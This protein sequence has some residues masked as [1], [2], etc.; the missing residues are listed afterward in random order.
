[1]VNHIAATLRHQMSIPLDSRNKVVIGTATLMVMA[2]AILGVVYL[3]ASG[4]GKREIRAQFAQAAGLAK[5]DS[6]SVAGVPVGSVTRTRLSGT[7]VTVD[8]KIDDNVALGRDTRASIKLTTLLGSRYVELQPAGSAGL[9]DETIALSH[10]TVPYDLQQVLGN[11]TTTF[12]QIDADQIGRSMTTLARQL[13]QTPALI[14]RVLDNVRVLSSVIADR[15]TQIGDLLRS[16]EQ[17]TTIVRGQQHNL[18]ELVTQGEQVLRAVL[19]RRV[20]ITRLLDATTDVAARLRTL[21][22]DDRSG[23]DRLITNLDGL[24]STLRRND[25]LLRNTLEILPVPIRNFANT[26]GTGNEVDFSDPAGPLVD[27]W[28]CAISKQ[29]DVVNLPPYFKDCR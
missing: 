5:G 10:T 28:M 14:P 4:I 9:R 29:A 27:S 21:T 17:L 12:E 15:R 1:M 16:T 26:T 13:D 7:F 19:A 24:L 11:A 8:M 23:L 25:A 20:M 2:L 6:V 18:G 22:V 3:G